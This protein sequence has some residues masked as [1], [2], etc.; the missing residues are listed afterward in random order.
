MTTR[1]A[2]TAILLLIPITVS[3]VFAAEL[4]FEQA[5]SAAL[6]Q[7]PALAASAARQES[8]RQLLIPAA[9]LPDPTLNFGIENLPIEGMDRF[10]FDGDFM[11]MRRIG[12]M[13]QV[14]NRAKRE[15]ESGI[16]EAQLVLVTAQQ[17]LS[18]L[19]VLQQ[20]SD[21][22]IRHYSTERKLVLL[23]AVLAENALQLQAV[24]AALVGGNGRAVDSVMVRQ[25]T[26]TLHNR[27][28]ELLEQKE[29]AVAD[30]RARIGNLADTPLS[31]EPP[32]W[33]VDSDHLSSSLHQHAELALLEP[34]LKLADAE[35]AR[36]EADRKPD[37]SVGVAYARRARDFEDMLMLEFSID[38]PM[39]ANS[40]QSPR[41]AARQAEKRAMEADVELMR[42]EHATMVEADL[43]SQR[44]LER[45]LQRQRDTVVP[46]AREQ[47]E[48]LLA[49]WRGNQGSLTELI[50][51][52]AAVLESEL[53]ILSLEEELTLLRVQLHLTY[54]SE[55]I[56]RQL[57]HSGQQQEITHE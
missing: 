25:E 53:A 38:L 22:W 9:E 45:A 46:L 34:G 48:L 10:R 39:F 4:T 15:A 29:R 49:A 2:L 44:R 14:P 3:T 24:Q 56:S 27:R 41:I 18:A 26:A 54:S 40:R 57:N 12:V 13:Q 7:S 43:A 17:N 33:Q 50:D 6:Q 30:L 16:A 55:A 42:R 52:R 19:Q 51:A 36:A 8:S 11:T 37:W 31:G 1:V 28:D 32:E 35:I 5:L 23:D 47:A 20:T 21:A